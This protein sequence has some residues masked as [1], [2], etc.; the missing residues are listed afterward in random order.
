MI[1]AQRWAG[2]ANQEEGNLSVKS[3]MKSWITG[4]DTSISN[5]LE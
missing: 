2:A 5:M 3:E 1:A 4:A